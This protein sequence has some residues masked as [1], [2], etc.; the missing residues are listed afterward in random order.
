MDQSAH[1]VNPLANL[2]IVSVL[3][4]LWHF[5]SFF[6]LFFLPDII[7]GVGIAYL[8][9][10]AMRQGEKEQKFFP[11]L[12]GETA[13]VRKI[14]STLTFFGMSAFIF[15]F[16]IVLFTLLDTLEP[17]GISFSFTPACGPNPT[18]G[19]ICAMGNWLHAFVA[20]VVATGLPGKFPWAFPNPFRSIFDGEMGS[21]QE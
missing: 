6:V 16:A 18:P 15:I 5:A 19:S 8:L 9:A 17:M 10:F 7:V 4:N 1:L 21:V 13:I 2:T 12:S 14:Y 3:Q 11:D 20:T